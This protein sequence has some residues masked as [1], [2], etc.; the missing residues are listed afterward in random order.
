LKADK[1]LHDAA[2][3]KHTQVLYQDCLNR[4]TYRQTNRREQWRESAENIKTCANLKTPRID[5]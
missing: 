4:Q 2:G 5:Y 1:A 3:F